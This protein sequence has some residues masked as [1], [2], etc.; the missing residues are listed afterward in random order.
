MKHLFSLAVLLLISV[1]A[2]S[3][4]VPKPADP[5]QKLDTVTL[6]NLILGTWVDMQDPTHIMTI[7]TD[8]V[9]ETISVTMGKD[10][11]QNNSYWNYK[12]TDNLFSTDDATCYSIEEY[13]DGY[14]HH[15]KIAINSV[16]SHYMLTGGEGNSVFKKK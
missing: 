4:N 11:K 5:C 10:T 8:S 13:K 1:C 12:I 16:D 15:V 3:Q 7:T 9:E 2:Y 14:S 6:K